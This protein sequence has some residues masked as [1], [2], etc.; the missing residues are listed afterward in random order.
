MRAVRND[1]TLQDFSSPSNKLSTTDSDLGINSFDAN[2]SGELKAQHKNKS[3]KRS[4]FFGNGNLLLS[5]ESD[6]ESPP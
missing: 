2:S 5:D 1:L 3:S 6:Y 4:A